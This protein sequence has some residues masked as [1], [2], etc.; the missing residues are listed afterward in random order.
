MHVMAGTLLGTRW[1]IAFAS[2]LVAIS[3]LCFYD[4]THRTQTILPSHPMGG[5]VGCVYSLSL[6]PSPSLSAS[7]STYP[8]NAQ[9]IACLLCISR[10]WVTGVTCLD[11]FPTLYCATRVGQ[12]ASC[13]DDRQALCLISSVSSSSGEV[14]LVPSD[15]YTHESHQTLARLSSDGQ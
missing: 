1:E 14:I 7:T 4:F 8:P 9:T 2:R 3:G 15:M 5:L 13:A 6:S 12:E 11:L 10:S